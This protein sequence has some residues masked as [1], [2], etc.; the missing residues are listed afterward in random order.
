MRDGGILRDLVASSAGDAALPI[1]A[2]LIRSAM[3]SPGFL[4]ST[5]T[6]EAALA[7]GEIGL[8]RSDEIRA[9]LTQWRTSLNYV[10]STQEHIRLITDQQIVPLLARDVALG[11]YLDA[12]I[13]TDVSATILTLPGTVGRSCSAAFS[14]DPHGAGHVQPSGRP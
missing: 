3:S 1:R 5:N 2:N 13:G 6:L 12:E 4:P 8:I 9:A 14:S 11:P 10:S 7:S